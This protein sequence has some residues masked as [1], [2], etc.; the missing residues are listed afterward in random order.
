MPSRA[1]NRLS[2]VR[3]GLLLLVL[4]GWAGAPLAVAA[5]TD[6]EAAYRKH[7]RDVL[8]QHARQV[9]QDAQWGNGEAA[10]EALDERAPTWRTID[11]ARVNRARALLGTA[12]GDGLITQGKRLHAWLEDP[13]GA[14]GFLRTLTALKRARNVE[15]ALDP[16]VPVSALHRPLVF[17]DE[18]DSPLCQRWLLA[19]AAARDDSEAEATEQRLA[20]LEREEAT[21]QKRRATLVS[22]LD[23]MARMELALTR[24]AGRRRVR[25]DA[26][27]DET[28]DERDAL[29]LADWVEELEL[30]LLYVTASRG[31]LRQKLCTEAL[32]I[33]RGE[34]EGVAARLT[35]S[36]RAKRRLARASQLE[37]IDAD[38]YELRAALEETEGAG[39]ASDAG[40]WQARARVLE[41][42]LALNAALRDT[43]ALQQRAESL[44]DPEVDAPP[45]D[46]SGT[47][48]LRAATPA[49]IVREAPLVRAH[50]HTL[51]APLV[52]HLHEVADERTR[53]LEAV[54]GEIATANH[55]PDGVAHDAARVRDA[56]A[57]FERAATPDAE[58][59]RHLAAARRWGDALSAEV[60]AH[61]SAWE[62]I[63]ALGA[64]ASAQHRTLKALRRTLANLG[65]R[66]FGVRV[67]RDLS[68][69]QLHAAWG[70]VRDTAQR[71][72]RWVT[73]RSDPNLGTF[74][75]AY[76]W[77]V[78]ACLL[79][80]IGGLWGA[81]AF[82]RWIDQWLDRQA[83]PIAALRNGL[84]LNAEAQV[85]RAQVAQA[86]A[87][88]RAIEQA[89]LED[90]SGRGR[91]AANGTH[92]G[93]EG[94][95]P[96]LAP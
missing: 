76:G 43:V 89:A 2:A 3:A 59:G 58:E 17:A 51:P 42:R 82:R 54:Q 49:T 25:K 15:A 30:H 47:D 90:A 34:R 36:A 84:S 16:A 18:L 5:P 96:E 81:R 24:A 93:M 20:S 70:D 41:A 60:K 46:V 26:L 27:G 73:F 38:A 55:P 66:S 9:L 19:R 78:V 52:T 8:V 57:A 4:G 11:P 75:Q 28:S 62:G 33:V 22:A 40:L 32:E 1:T 83:E 37:Q 64:R 74:L 31:A 65:P 67:D 6:D 72:E 56:L 77:R 53:Q 35:S 92:E 87:E 10:R 95:S 50:L 48:R 69:D 12:P 13:K 14:P 44:M 79:V 80:L 68:V 39:R 7:R 88:V 71:A 21:W 23:D 63:Q 61:A 45:A 29:A 91:D 94:A 86:D 85:E